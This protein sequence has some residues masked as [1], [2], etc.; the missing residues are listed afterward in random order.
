MTSYISS[1]M[2]DFAARGDARNPTS[3]DVDAAVRSPSEKEIREI[4][5]AEVLETDNRYFELATERADLNGAQLVWS[6]D[7]TSIPLGCVIL[8]VE[9]P[10]SP[11][12][13]LEWLTRFEDA[14]LDVDCRLARIYLQKSNPVLEQALTRTGYERR[15]EVAFVGPA[16]APPAGTTVSLHLMTDEADLDKM[17][18]IDAEDSYGPD[19]HTADNATWNEI[20][21]QKWRT[22]ELSLY[23]IKYQEEICGTVGAMHAAHILRLKN[24]VVRPSYRKQGIGRAATLALWEMA[25]DSGK[26]LAVFGVPGGGG[27]ATYKS[28]GLHPTLPQDEWCKI[29]SVETGT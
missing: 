10:E 27:Y 3:R 2:K 7:R 22:G 19:G 4:C 21:R 1:S 25:F 11:E 26:R 14:I 23:F 29:L 6:P 16:T 9:E 13:A 5:T 15:P 17:A 8:R 24:L 28:A 20:I 12:Q 18:E